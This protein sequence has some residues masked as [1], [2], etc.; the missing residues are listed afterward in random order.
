MLIGVLADTAVTQASAVMALRRANPRYRVRRLYGEA[1]KIG[2]DHLSATMHTLVLAYAG[3]TLPLLL[4]QRAGQS[5]TT[6]LVNGQS[7]AVASDRNTARGS[8]PPSPLS[9]SAAVA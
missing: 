7:L 6:N 3:A 5:T 2:R 8:P 1:F 9:G 4:L